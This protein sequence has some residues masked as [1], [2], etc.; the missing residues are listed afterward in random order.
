M[1]PPARSLTR[2]HPGLRDRG[3]DHGDVKLVGIAGVHEQQVER[4]VVEGIAATGRAV[5]SDHNF[6]GRHDVVCLRGVH[7]IR[8]FIV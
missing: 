5:D 1:S 4:G 2:R 7:I 3:P 8:C 6:A